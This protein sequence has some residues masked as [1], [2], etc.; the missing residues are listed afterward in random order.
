MASTTV[1]RRRLALR[2]AALAL[3][4][5]VA[6][7]AGDG[8][9]LDANGRPPSESGAGLPP[10]TGVS[11]KA[12]QD[13]VFTPV[14]STCHAGAAAP[15]GLR[16]D[17]GNAYASLVNVASVEV[18]ALR[19]V[20]PGDA[21]NSYLVQKIEGRAAVGA[22]MPLGGPALSQANI[23]L[24][25]AWIAAGA[26]PAV[27]AASDAGSFK[28]AST[29]PG[30]GEVAPAGT[31]TLTLVFTGPV[32]ATLARSSTL[33]LARV[34]GPEVELA[35]IDV[36]S[37]NPTVVYLRAASPL[38]PGE[39]L[40]TARGSGATPL[41]DESARALDGDGDGRA[42]GDF[43]LG[44]EVATPTAAAALPQAIVTGEHP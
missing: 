2:A 9:G 17:A 31:A 26:P 22:R 10:A 3:G 42:G 34:D 25:R 7:C 30:A 5:A 40:L 33:A 24:V 35:S 15:L 14:C 38:P 37:G 8:K 6:G 21:A 12:V 41:A 11:F 43:A 27:A 16:L 4:A 39:Y 29:M 20:L 32:D 1:P 44:F 19:R 13:N 28:V 23:D 36:A 18:G